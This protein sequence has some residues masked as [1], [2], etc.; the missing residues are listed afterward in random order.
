[1][2]IKSAVSRMSPRSSRMGTQEALD[3]FIMR[4]NEYLLTTQAVAENDK[5]PED[6]RSRMDSLG[7]SS[8]AR[9]AVLHKRE[10][11]KGRRH[12]ETGG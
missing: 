2:R 3:D 4:S 12:Q 8:L 6:E 5:A 9:N 10:S 7:G 11:W 1:M